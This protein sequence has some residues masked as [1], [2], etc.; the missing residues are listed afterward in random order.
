MKILNRSLRSWGQMLSFF[1]FPS[2]FRQASSILREPLTLVYAQS[3]NIL[4]GAV[5][6]L[7]L[8]TTSKSLKALITTS[9]SKTVAS[10]L[11]C[12]F[13]SY[14]YTCT[15]EDHLLPV[16]TEFCCTVMANFSSNVCLL[17]KEWH[18]ENLC[19]YYG[20]KD[21]RRVVFLT[22]YAIYHPYLVFPTVCDSAIPTSGKFCHHL[23][24]LTRL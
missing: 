4:Y 5:I 19:T 6:T 16:W 14:L 21:W 23:C 18:K 17:L 8:F 15:L 13:H 2:F 20:Y 10:S 12:H 22:V 11:G 7:L 9:S 3:S 24:S 1:F